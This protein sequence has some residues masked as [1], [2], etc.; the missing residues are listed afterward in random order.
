MIEGFARELPEEV[1]TDAV[2]FGHQ[3]IVQIIDLIEELREK[4]GLGKKEPPPVA[5]P[6]RL[7]GILADLYLDDLKQR[8]LT[9]LKLERYAKVD[10]LKAQL[11]EKYLPAEGPE[12]TSRQFAQAWTALEERAFRELALAGKRLDGRELQGDPAR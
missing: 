1:I 11:K 10:E 7:A 9:K 12:Y 3:Q 4:A 8:K 5:E 2:M 6:N